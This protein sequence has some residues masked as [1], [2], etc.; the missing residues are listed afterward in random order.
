MVQPPLLDESA[1]LRVAVVDV[2]A[3]VILVRQ[4]VV[5]AALLQ[6]PADD[7]R[8]TREGDLVRRPERGSACA[9]PT[10]KV[11]QRAHNLGSV[12]DSPIF[13]VGAPEPTSVL[14]TLDVGIEANSHRPAP[15]LGCE[16]DVVTRREP[17][18]AIGNRDDPRS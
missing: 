2:A 16:A 13:E 7:A 17:R 10:D 8:P 5:N 11:E 3:E 4:E 9:P 12:L 18:G 6:D 15:Q 14:R 1:P